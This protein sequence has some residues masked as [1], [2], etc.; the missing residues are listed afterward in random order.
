MGRM[1]LSKDIEKGRV[2][3]REDFPVVVE[4]MKVIFEQCDSIIGALPY[5]SL[6]YEEQTVRSDIDCLVLYDYRDHGNVLAV[7]EKAINFAAERFIPVE[8]VLIDTVAA[9]ECVHTIDASLWWHLEHIIP[10]HA[11]KQNPLLFLLPNGNEQPVKE[12]LRRK[13][14]SL[15]KRRC[16]MHTSHGEDY[17]RNLQKF[18][19]APVRVARKMLWESGV[20]MNDDST[21]SV[22]VHYPEQFPERRSQ[23]LSLVKTDGQYTQELIRQQRHFDSMEYSAFIL[24][25]EAKIDCIIDFVRLNALEL[26]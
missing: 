25:L 4:M 15:Q 2:P 12:Y 18:W 6:C 13:L 16:V 3:K 21:S 9:K 10:N 1:F 5:G 17:I 26:K 11:I 8:F 24:A 7:I 22:I 14:A 23:F 19:E 20:D